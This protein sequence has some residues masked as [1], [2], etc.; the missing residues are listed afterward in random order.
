MPMGFINDYIQIL[1]IFSA[2]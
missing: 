1:H 2:T